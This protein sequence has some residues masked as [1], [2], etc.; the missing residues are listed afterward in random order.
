MTGGMIYD[1]EENKDTGLWQ[2]FW[3]QLKNKNKNNIYSGIYNRYKFATVTSS[4][5][6][7][8]NSNSFSRINI[9]IVP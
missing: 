8:Y 3:F 9:L 2:R 1:T 6:E 5:I 4:V 7:Y